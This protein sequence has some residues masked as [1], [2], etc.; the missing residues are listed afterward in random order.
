MSVA[1]GTCKSAV[2]VENSRK[3][4]KRSKFLLAPLVNEKEFRTSTRRKMSVGK[5]PGRSIVSSAQQPVLAVNSS[6]LS[7]P[8]TCKSSASAPQ[9]GQKRDAASRT[10]VELST[11]SKRRAIRKSAAEGRKNISIQRSTAVGSGGHLDI[12]KRKK[13]WF[14]SSLS[15]KNKSLSLSFSSQRIRIPGSINGL[16]VPELTVDTASD[17]TCV[18]PIIFETSSNFMQGYY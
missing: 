7:V 14:S 3:D 13:S 15:R 9:S 2:V 10:V 1:L 11:G 8:I 12:N 5:V 17:V 4:A 6:D 18:S 16:F